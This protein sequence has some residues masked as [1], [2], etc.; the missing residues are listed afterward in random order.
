MATGLQ[1]QYLCRL[2]PPQNVD[3]AKAW[4]CHN[5]ARNMVK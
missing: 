1:S 3:L 5:L 4:L 2:A